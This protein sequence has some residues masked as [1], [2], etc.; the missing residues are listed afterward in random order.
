MYLIAYM[1]IYACIHN[2]SSF[3]TVQKLHHQI[4]EAETSSCT[5]AYTY[6]HRL[7]SFND[8]YQTMPRLVMVI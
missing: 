2:L 8:K 7:H 4:R 1:D 3:I 6:H 5:C